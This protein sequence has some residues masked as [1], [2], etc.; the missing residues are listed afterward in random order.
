MNFRLYLTIVLIIKYASLFNFVEFHKYLFF[1]VFVKTKIW[2][3]TLMFLLLIWSNVESY[4][5]KRCNW[6]SFENS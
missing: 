5:R 1:L 6:R 2:V 4:T 3:F